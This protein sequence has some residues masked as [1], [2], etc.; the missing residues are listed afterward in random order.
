MLTAREELIKRLYD[1]AAA[2]DG[3]SDLDAKLLREAALELA[4]ETN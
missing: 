2:L 3:V 4:Y 1:R